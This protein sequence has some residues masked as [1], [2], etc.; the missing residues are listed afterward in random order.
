[1]IETWQQT[2][3]HGIHLSCR[4]AGPKGAPVWLFLHGFPEAAFVWDDMLLHFS[5]PAN[6]GYRCVAPNL[7]GY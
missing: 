1:M 3:P 7:R 6:G 4:A 2:L 5:K